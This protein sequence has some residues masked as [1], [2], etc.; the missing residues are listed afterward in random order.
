[1]K[2]LIAFTKKE[3]LENIRTGKLLIMI[4]IFTIFGIMNPAIAKMTPW[5]YDMLSEQ[6]AEQGIM[7]NE[8][9]VD[10][11]TSWMQYYKNIS[12]GLI[13][14]V[15]MFCGI[16]AN[17]FQKGT[18]INILTKGLS[19]WKVI[20]AKSIISVFIWTLCYWLA[21]GITYGYNAYFWDNSIAR[22]LFVS[23]FFIYLVGIWLLSLLFV[24]SV[25]FETS[26]GVLLFTGAIFAIIYI[27][28]MIPTISDY[29]PTKLLS[30][31]DLLTNA[32]EPSDYIKSFIVTLVCLILCYTIT[33]INFNKKRI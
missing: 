16:L 24:S 11:M 32:S 22:H 10:A 4:I 13:V 18:L 15:V 9:T 26:S 31:G 1:M 17:E 27:A 2:Q 25:F 19:R 12:M 7:I 20:T 5:I 21:Y 8:M 3:W 33:I 14:L 29:L 6:M 28:S 23:A 30:S